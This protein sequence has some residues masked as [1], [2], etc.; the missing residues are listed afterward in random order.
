[1]S[2]E[3]NLSEIKK[4]YHGT[5]RSYIQGFIASLLLTLASFALVIT[6]IISGH[7]LVYTIVGLG[8]IQAA[9]QLRFF[10]KLGHEDHPR[11]ETLVFG[12][13]LFVLLLI[14]ICSLWIMK[15][16]NDRLM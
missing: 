16:L 5:L 10:L 9:V 3:P 14:A 15:N 11:W 6:R 13:M 12:F 4:E 1:M 8:L 2:S 7:F